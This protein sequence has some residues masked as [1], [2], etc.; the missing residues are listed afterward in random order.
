SS[1][2]MLRLLVILAIPTIGFSAFMNNTP[3]VALMIPVALT[4]ARR[5][6]VAPSRVL[7]PLSY[8][9]ILGGTCTLFGTS[10]NILI[11]ALYRQGGGPGFGV[12]EFTPLGLVFVGVGLVYV[13]LFA[14][15]I[16]PER[17]ALADLLA[18]QAPGR[19]ITEVIL[20]PGSRYLGMTLGT[21]FPENRDVTT[22]QLVRGE[23]AMLKPKPDFVLEAG[24]VLYVESTARNLHH[25][26]QDPELERGTA[27]AD[28]ERV[29]IFS[30][31]AGDFPS[32]PAALGLQDSPSTERIQSVDLRIAEAVVTPASRFVDRPVR[33]LGL[34]RKHGVQVLAIR[35]HGKQ[36]Q[37]QLRDLRLSAGDVLL[38][39]GEPTSLRLIHEEGDFL[40]VEGVEK[41]LTFPEKAPLAV[42]ILMAV[43]MA[44]LGV[45]PIVFLA[46]A[47]I[48]AMLAT[49]CLDMR[50]AVRAVEPEVLL[51]LAST[52]PL[53][54][55]IQKVGLASQAAGGLIHLV[56]EAN[57]W[58]VVATLYLI[59]SFLT[60]IVSN[61]ATAVLLAPVALG[62]A[63]HLGIDPKPL[64][65]AVAFGASASFATPIGYQ[66]NT[67][68]MGPGGYK[69]RDYLKFGLPLN[70]LMA[71][72]AS[73][74]IPWIWPL[75][76]T[77]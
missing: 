3:V 69:F 55:A 39:Q 38:V 4:M 62:A 30:L 11:D 50:A 59:T 48:G 64:L 34:S 56:G 27:V 13:L 19:F 20:K 57:P 58:W 60:E 46:L 17:T 16:L 63:A 73:I 24:D 23:E 6:K 42:G 44:A 7:L 53:G 37:Y 1:G 52:I 22:L 45:A 47:G 32:D 74:L 67:L 51:L 75:T 77:P 14:P 36:H 49:R 43:I 5:A 41:T 61:N 68:V 21:A 29:P 15:R 9:S 70:L 31:L 54:I 66:T 8:F 18:I 10:T 25:I 76:A 72:T 12:F 26:F 65:I 33:S 28:E 35:R 71:L 40:L 2:G